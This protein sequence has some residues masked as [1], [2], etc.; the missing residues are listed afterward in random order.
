MPPPLKS[1]AFSIWSKGYNIYHHCKVDIL[2][3]VKTICNVEIDV[4][5]KP[6]TAMNTRAFSTDTCGVRLQ[7]GRGPRVPSLRDGPGRL[8]GG[9]YTT[10]IA[11]YLRLFQDT[12][13]VLVYYA[14]CTE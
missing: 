7:W 5:L 14:V 9:T 6:W 2:C 11:Y 1:T 3:F 10:Y 4:Q 12:N 13:F 8:L